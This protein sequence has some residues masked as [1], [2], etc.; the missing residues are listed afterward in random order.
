MSIPCPMPR[1]FFDGSGNDR[2]STET[3]AVH[4]F[5]AARTTECPFQCVYQSTSGMP[6][7]RTSGAASTA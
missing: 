6:S 4:T 5:S 7:G 2:A 1:T 3:T